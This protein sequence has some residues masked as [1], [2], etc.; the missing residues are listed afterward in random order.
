LSI[1]SHPDDND[2]KQA[3]AELCQAQFNRGLAKPALPDVD[4]VFS[5]IKVVFRLLKIEVVFQLP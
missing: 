3:G 1:F 2:G 4:V 5:C